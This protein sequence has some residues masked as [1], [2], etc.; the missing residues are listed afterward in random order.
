MSIQLV[1]E[2]ERCE[3]SAGDQ[4]L[5]QAGDTA[6]LQVR[7]NPVPIGGPDDVPVE[8][9]GAEG[10]P[11]EAELVAEEIQGVTGEIIA[12]GFGDLAEGLPRPSS[13]AA[14]PSL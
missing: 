8:I 4:V 9:G 3:H 14:T 12:P 5:R 11:R 7:Q 10:T 6:C 1:A 13:D 2:A